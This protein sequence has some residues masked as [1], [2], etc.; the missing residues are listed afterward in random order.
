MRARARASRCS[1][2]HPWRPRLRVSPAKHHDLDH[3]QPA[4]A[5][6]GSTAVQ[7]PSSLNARSP[8]ASGS[9]SGLRGLPDRTSDPSV[10]LETATHSER[11]IRNL[12]L[13]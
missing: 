9:R 5:W 7:T 2:A 8:I 11:E 4:S 6:S 12:T 13:S 1:V 3:H 10:R